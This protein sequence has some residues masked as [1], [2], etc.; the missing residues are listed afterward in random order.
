MGKQKCL[1]IFFTSFDKFPLVAGFFCS[2]FFEKVSTVIKFEASGKFSLVD[3]IGT[4]SGSHHDRFRCKC[5][6]FAV[7]PFEN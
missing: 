1:S 7:A 2:I 4:C 3:S 5:Y 6:G